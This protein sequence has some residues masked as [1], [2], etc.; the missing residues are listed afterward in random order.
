MYFGINKLKHLDISLHTM[1]VNFY[2]A[3]YNIKAKVIKI[4]SCK[5]PCYY[6]FV[7]WESRVMFLKGC[8]GINYNSLFTA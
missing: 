3:N 5:T 4:L 2:Q 8:C 1:F 6:G 7:S